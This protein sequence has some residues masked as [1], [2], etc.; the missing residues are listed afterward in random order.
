VDNRF[1]TR[2]IAIVVC[3]A[4]LLAGVFAQAI[5]LALVDSLKKPVSLRR[6]MRPLRE[7]IEQ[8]AK[9][10]ETELEYA[11]LPD[12]ARVMRAIQTTLE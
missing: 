8:V 7:L 5:D 11:V 9:Q 12:L 3:G 6:K 10:T 4:S 2:W 1:W